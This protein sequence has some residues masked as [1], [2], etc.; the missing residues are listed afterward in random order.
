MEADISLVMASSSL[1]VDG[2]S[3]IA[4]IEPTHVREK[5]NKTIWT[6]RIEGVEVDKIESV[7]NRLMETLD[8]DRK[9]VDS[10]EVWVT[11]NTTSEFA[12]VAFSGTCLAKLAEH[13][14]DLFISTYAEGRDWGEA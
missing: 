4:G 14:V 10:C 8:R 7:I 2:I 9:G 13:N 5:S 11:V 3:A 12:G 1:S 6:H